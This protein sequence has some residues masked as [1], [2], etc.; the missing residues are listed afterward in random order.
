MRDELGP[1]PLGE[2]TDRLAGEIRQL[3]RMRLVFTRPYF[4]TAISMS[5]TLAVWTYSGG[6]ISASGSHLAGLQV[7]LQLGPLRADVLALSGPPSSGPVISRGR[8]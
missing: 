1:L 6:S 4:G 5:I 7:S 2:A 3:V 8:R